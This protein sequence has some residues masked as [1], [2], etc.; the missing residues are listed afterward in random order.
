MKIP[1]STY[2]GWWSA[3]AIA[4]TNP[5]GGGHDSAPNIVASGLPGTD[6]ISLTIGYYHSELSEDRAATPCDRFLTMCKIR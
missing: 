1:I 3:I 6:C 4:L 5:V 2:S